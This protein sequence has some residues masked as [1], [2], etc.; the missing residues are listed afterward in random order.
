MFNIKLK[1]QT[2]RTNKNFFI[3]CSNSKRFSKKDV[4]LEKYQW[5]ENDRKNLTVLSPYEEQ[6]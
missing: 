1:C 6:S 5:I 3:F 2:C 4:S